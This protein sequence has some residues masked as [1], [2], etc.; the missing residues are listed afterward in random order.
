MPLTRR[1]VYRRRRIAVFGGAALVLG[2]GFYLP[3]TL[4]APL[5]EVSAQVVAHELPAVAAPAIEFPGYGAAGIAAIGYD[6][7]LA[8][9]GSP[10][11]LPIASITKIVTALVV[12]EAQPLAADQAGPEIV[13]SGVDEQF[14][15]DQIAQG[16]SVRSVYAGQVI[17]QRDALVVM[18][19]AS[20]NNYA[21]S[22]A[23]WA[24][25]SEAA[26]L[27][28]TRAWLDARGLTGTTITDP[29]G[30]LASNVS[31]VADLVE[32]AKLTAQ[33][34][35]L[36][37]IVATVTADVPDVGTV[38]NRNGLLGLSG[39][40]G[41]KTGTLPESG[42]CLLFS[43]DA[44]VGAQ[45]VT[46]VGV[47][48]GG[49]D[50]DTINAAIESLIAQ[51][52]AGFQEVVLTTEGEPFA[53]YDTLWGDESAAV[54]TESISIAVWSGV[55]VTMAIDADAVR[56]AESGS[57]VGELVFT[58]GER[59]IPVGLRLDATI[60]DPGAWWRLTNPEKLF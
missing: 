48:L 41:I 21:Q 30:I 58:V 44:I 24:Y 2:A 51:A 3:L 10:D 14:Y 33:H 49:P 38:N 17:T 57:P 1:Q 25:G 34:P 42:S 11:P 23:T 5:Q 55:P 54:A 18:L 12:L 53:T 19:L 39:V 13:F 27:D 45:T 22:L 28:A 43:A 15:A 36:A 26:F 59:E 31:T 56:L 35:V 4:L 37:G 9:S 8:S 60:D 46:L 32:L 50:H 47:V 16:G 40:D 20:A 52:T 29:S 7:V 6:G